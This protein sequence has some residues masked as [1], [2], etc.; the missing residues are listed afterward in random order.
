[1]MVAAVM[2][3]L[4]LLIAGRLAFAGG[5]SRLRHD[6][7]DGAGSEQGG[8]WTYLLWFAA[9]VAG[10][11]LVGFLVASIVFFIAFLRG[12]A[13]CSWLTTLTLTAIANAALVGI[14]DI[15]VLDF[16][17]GVL[18]SLVDLPWPLR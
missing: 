10:T 1:M 12:P 11:A 15:L 14:A 16:P 3:P 13:R 5:G 4:S 8:F 17:A 9:L 2:L 18:Q 7:E 6:A